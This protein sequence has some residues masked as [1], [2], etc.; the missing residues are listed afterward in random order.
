ME[1]KQMICPSCT[2][3]VQVPTDL[4]RITCAYCGSELIVGY[5]EGNMNL[6]LAQKI[7]ETLQNVGQET[8]GAIRENTGVT[9]TELKR[10]QIGQQIA[11]VQIQLSNIRT[12]IRT[13][14]REKNLSRAAKRQLKEL[15]K[16]EQACLLQIRNLQSFLTDTKGTHQVVKDSGVSKAKSSTQAS[17]LKKGCAWGC[18]TYLVVVLA[19]GMVAIP[20]DELFFNVTTDSDVNR[21]FFSIAVWIGFLIG[22]AVFF[23]F[24]FPDANIWKRLP[25]RGPV[26]NSKK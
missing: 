8:Q 24:L 19:L 5:S 23:Y 26:N 16:E 4:G 12:E 10:L 18:V 21:P 14:E 9:Q 6:S 13:I 1:L 3:A 15:R 11:T 22:V 20:L 17:P 2:G 7:K 25:F